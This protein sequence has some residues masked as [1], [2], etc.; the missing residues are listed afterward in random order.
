[1]PL[2]PLAGVFVYS[3]CGK[4]VFPSLLWNFPPS[5]TLTSFPSPG[6]WVLPCSR[7]SLPYKFW[8]TI[9]RTKKI[10]LQRF[11]LGLYWRTAYVKKSWLLKDIKSTN[12]QT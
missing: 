6:Y 1:V 5:A 7:W 11:W 3:S 12:L 2:L 4:W 8:M 9:S 10:I